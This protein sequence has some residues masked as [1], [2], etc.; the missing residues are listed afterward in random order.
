MIK[1]DLHVHSQYSEDATGSPEEIIKILKKKGLQGMAITDHNTVD[2][3][4][5]ALKTTE[6]DFIIIPGI[7]ISTISGHII[8]LNVKEVIPRDRSLEETIESIHDHNGLPIVPHLFRR[9]SGIKKK[10]LEQIKNKV[11]AMEVFNGCSL[12]KT[13]IKTSNIAERYNLGGV[14]GSDTH[15]AEYA[16]YGYTLVDTT[17]TS[18]DSILSEIE[19]KKTWGEGTTMPL[20]YRRDRMMLSIKQFFQRGFKRI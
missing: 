11:P 6:K 7:E 18:I 8:A 14:G 10:G 16:G 19:K 4:L 3:A 9:M 1:I 12:P 2:G 20:Q 15:K 5:K 17:D 13:N